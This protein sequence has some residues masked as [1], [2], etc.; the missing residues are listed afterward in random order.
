MQEGEVRET[1]GIKIKHIETPSSGIGPEGP[2]A[3]KIK[4]NIFLKFDS[5]NWKR[6]FII[7]MDTGAEVSMIQ[8]RQ[9]PPKVE[10]NTSTILNYSVIQTNSHKKYTLGFAW[11]P[12]KVG[13]R[14]LETKMH[15]RAEIYITIDYD[16]ILG[17]GFC[18]DMEILLDCR[19]KVAH[20]PH[21]NNAAVQ[22][23][24]P[25]IVPAHKKKVLKIKLNSDS[26]PVGLVDVTN[27][28]E[29]ITVPSS[30]SQRREYATVLIPITNS[31]DK[32]VNA[33]SLE[34]T[35]KPITRV[36]KMK[37]IRNRNNKYKTLLQE[38]LRLTHLSKFEKQAFFSLLW[39]Y[40]DIVFLPGD[41]L[42]NKKILLAPGMLQSGLFLKNSTPKINRNG[43][44]SLIIENLMKF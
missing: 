32:P 20:F 25:M 29:G 38:A 26:Y 42:E 9:F 17:N 4:R 22:F 15:I 21:H 1:R 37:L 33:E 28:V 18:H 19:N 5:P 8:K 13:D 40:N 36:L 14:E 30:I 6:T 7:Q 44:S 2:T 24:N 10:I 11:I 3:E 41:N 35:L 43:V 31:T 39:E 12:I 23:Y 16:G 34:L 27:P